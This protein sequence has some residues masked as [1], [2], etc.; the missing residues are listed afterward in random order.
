M[1][2]QDEFIDVKGLCKEWSVSK[3]LVY[4]LSHRQ[5]LPVYKPF[6]GKIWF[7]RSDVIALMN[8]HKVLCENEINELVN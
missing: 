8:D 2:I 7:K 4:K 3:S 1:S 5:V 6:G